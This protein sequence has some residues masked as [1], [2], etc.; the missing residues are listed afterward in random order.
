MSLSLSTTQPCMQQQFYQ[1][2]LQFA[3]SRVGLVRPDNRKGLLTGLCA[4]GGA[5]VGSCGVASLCLGCISWGALL[6]GGF[7]PCI[8]PCIPLGCKERPWGRACIASQCNPPRWPCCAC[9]ARCKG[10][11]RTRPT[12]RRTPVR[13]VRP[14]GCTRWGLGCIPLGCRRGASVPL[15]NAPHP[16]SKAMQLLHC[17]AMQPM[18]CTQ[19]KRCNTQGEVKGAAK[20][21]PNPVGYWPRNTVWEAEGSLL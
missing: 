13:P 4:N 19:A 7:G 18:H 5:C 17:F 21:T 9:I 10:G 3:T 15:S 20:K 16:P 14:M 12:E 2:W 8:R 1:Q 11:L 6:R